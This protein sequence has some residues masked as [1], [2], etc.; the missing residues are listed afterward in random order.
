MIVSYSSKNFHEPSN[1]PTATNLTII[2]KNEGVIG[3]LCILKDLGLNGCSG[4]IAMLTD[5]IILRQED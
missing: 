5:L 3:K 4:I 2:Q 1:Y